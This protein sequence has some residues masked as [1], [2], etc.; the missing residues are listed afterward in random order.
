MLLEV[1][2]CLDRSRSGAASV[3][4][5]APHSRHSGT[6]NIVDGVVADVDRILSLHPCLCKG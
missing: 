5:D 6:L 2:E 1:V 3:Q 4:K